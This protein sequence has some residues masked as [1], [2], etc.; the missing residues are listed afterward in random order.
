MRAYII[1]RLLLL[2]PT[3][4]LITI[5]IFLLARLVPGT[6]I[7]LMLAQ[8]P[9]TQGQIGRAALEH[10]LGFDVPIHIQYVR[11]IGAIITHGDLGDS[12]WSRQPVAP[13]VLR[14]FPISFELWFIAILIG[15]LIAIPIGIYSAIRQDSVGDYIARGFAIACIA[16]PSFWLGTLVMVFPSVWWRWSPPVEYL[17]FFQNPGQNL[18]MFLPPAIILGMG[19]SGMVMRMTRTMMLE[20][21]RQ[22]YIRTAWSKGLTEKVV[23]L[24]HAMK[25]ALIPIV[26]IIGLQIPAVIGGSIILETIFQIPGVGRLMIDT[27]FNR[28]YPILQGINLITAAIVLLVNLGVDMTYAYLDPRVH[29]E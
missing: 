4:F 14:R 22:D 16:L 2:I 29:Y 26:T 9:A 18:Q 3:L 24:R 7:D 10:E 25:N 28:D 27:V 21:L 5:I 23:V 19:L 13:N 12:L 8:Q 11:W 6:A 15:L 17:S 20:V 1:R